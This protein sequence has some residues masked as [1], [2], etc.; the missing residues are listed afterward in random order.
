MGSG[1]VGIGSNGA[2]LLLMP[3]AVAQSDFPAAIIAARLLRSRV[4][5]GNL[6][7]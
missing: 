2:S 3:V 7:P 4:H 5:L 6:G 1:V